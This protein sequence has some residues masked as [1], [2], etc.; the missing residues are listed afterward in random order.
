MFTYFEDGKPVRKNPDNLSKVA[1]FLKYLFLDE[2]EILFAA[3]KEN[4]EEAAKY[5]L[6]IGVRN[7]IVTRGSRGS[8]IFTPNHIIEIPAFPPIELVDPTG[9]GDTYMA[10]FIYGTSLFND[11]KKVGDFAA[12]SATMVIEKGGVFDGNIKKVHERLSNI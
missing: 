1:P 4:I 5:F 8:I 11:I 12:M 9:A 3:Q 7:V 2:E 6:Y 10:A